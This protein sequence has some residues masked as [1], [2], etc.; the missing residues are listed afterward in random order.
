MAHIL[1][2]KD[3]KI[4]C[5]ACNQDETEHSLFRLMFPDSTSKALLYWK[6]RKTH[7]FAGQRAEDCGG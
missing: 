7:H 4:V 2:T 1:V 3:L 5:R 6:K